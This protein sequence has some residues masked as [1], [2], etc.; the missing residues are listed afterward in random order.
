ML[1]I[2]DKN[3]TPTTRVSTSIGLLLMIMAAMPRKIALTRSEMS[4]I[5]GMKLVV[6]PDAT[7]LIAVNE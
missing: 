6:L 1:G 7:R 2:I 3:E 4:L 5:S